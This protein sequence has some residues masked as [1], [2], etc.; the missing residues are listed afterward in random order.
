MPLV[1]AL[2]VFSVIL[3]ITV[4]RV[5]LELYAALFAVAALASVAFLFLYFRLF[6]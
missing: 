1:L 4:P 6:Y 2:L 3:G 5:G